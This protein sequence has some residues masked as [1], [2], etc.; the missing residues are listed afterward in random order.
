MSRSYAYG[1]A[2]H[3]RNIELRLESDR[4]PLELGLRADNCSFCV[5]HH[6]IFTSDPGGELA[7]TVRDPNFVTRY[8]FGTRTADFVLCRACGVFAVAMMD[9]PPIAVV[10]V[11]VLDAR[12]DFL[13][14]E[15]TIGSF[16]GESVEERLARRKARWTPIVAFAVTGAR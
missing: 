5:K 15:L 7:V 14:N 6:A 8:R 3:C 4:T 11:N 16:D 13:K 10:N 9:E 12:A 1:G 2:C